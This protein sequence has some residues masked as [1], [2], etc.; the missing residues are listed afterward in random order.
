MKRRFKEIPVAEITLRKFEKPYGS[1]E[2]ILRRFC[3]SLGLLQ[4]GD[5]RDVVI[6]I[7]KLFLEAKKRRKFLSPE[8]IYELIQERRERGATQANLRRHITRLKRI[9]LV[10]KT[11]QGYRLRE[12]LS[13]EE[14]VLGVKKL[15]IE[16]TFERILEYAK[17][18]EISFC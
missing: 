1:K 18:V 5:S 12:W 9:G 13:L 16:P 4:P 7:L 14:L 11:R 2:D 10:E 3:I 6:E 17:E 15:L 8:R